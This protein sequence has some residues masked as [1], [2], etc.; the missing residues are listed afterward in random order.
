MRRDV[1]FWIGVAIFL[2]VVVAGTILYVQR[3]PLAEEV[4]EVTPRHEQQLALFTQRVSVLLTVATLIVG[5]ALALLLHFWE[6]KVQSLAALRWAT[7]CLLAAGL[8]IY[9]GYMAFDAAIWMLGA[10]FFNLETTALR[11]PSLLQLATS[12]LSM[13]FLGFSVLAG[14]VGKQEAQ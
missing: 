14:P 6:A 10:R 7:L 4:V 11:V 9:F 12:G 8:S 1:T 3:V 5:G 2:I 13:L